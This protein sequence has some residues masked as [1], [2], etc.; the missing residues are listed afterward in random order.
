MGGTAW[1]FKSPDK[2]F[3]I[4]GDG[5]CYFRALSFI[6]TGTEIYH[7][8]IQQVICDF[9][10][11]HYDDLNIF[12]DEFVDGEY[13][14]LKK[15]MRKNGTWGD[16]IRNYRDGYNGK[17]GC[18]HVQPYWVFEIPESICPGTNNQIFL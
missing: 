3:I 9:I 7:V 2:V 13:Y 10:E 1:G 12:L 18:N 17:E 4:R 16:R 5:N 14:L 8:K 11:V 15:K 6:L